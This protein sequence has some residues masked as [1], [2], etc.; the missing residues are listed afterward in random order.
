MRTNRPRVLLDTNLWVAFFKTP[1]ATMRDLLR[2]GRVA[3][4]SVV[5]GELSVGSLPHRTLIIDYLQR[6]PKVAEAAQAE[7]RAMIEHRR[8]WGRGLQWNDVLLLASARIDGVQL[9]TYDK[10]LA[11]AATELGVAWTGGA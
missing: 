7:A 4:H 3:T 8:L 2:N 6:L 5:I 11:Q 9:W 1:L 10:R